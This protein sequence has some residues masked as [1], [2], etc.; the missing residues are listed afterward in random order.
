MPTVL[1]NIGISGDYGQIVFHNDGTNN[2]ATS[3]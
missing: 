2:I 3:L 1:N